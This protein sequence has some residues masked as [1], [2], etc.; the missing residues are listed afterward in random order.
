MLI[1]G[2][3]HLDDLAE[4]GSTVILHPLA[5]LLYC[6]P[7]RGTGKKGDLGC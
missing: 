6:V 4:S 2:F 3:P 1:F 7:I 5:L